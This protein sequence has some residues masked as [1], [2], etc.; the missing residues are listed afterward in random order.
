MAIQ[1]VYTYPIHLFW[2]PK[3]AKKRF[4]LLLRAVKDGLKGKLGNTF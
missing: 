4:K 1:L 3:I 2:M